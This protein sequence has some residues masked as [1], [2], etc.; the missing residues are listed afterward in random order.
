MTKPVTGVLF[1]VDGTLVDS[2]YL[3]AVA[4]WQAFR[5]Y[6]YD[7]PMA[8]IHRAIG[9][10][11]DKILDALL[12]PDHDSSSDE[13]L[14][15]AHSALYAPHWP[16][17]RP[18]PGARRLLDTCA[19]RG[20]SVVLATSASRPELDALL[21]CLDV[22]SALTAVTSADDASQSKP[23][24][25]ILEVALERSGLSAEEAVFVGDSVWD[26]HAAAQLS[27]PCI[28]LTS[29][30]LCA[31][32]LLDHGAAAI[33]EDPQDLLDHLDEALTS[34]FRKSLAEAG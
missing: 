16:A 9:M 2:V 24:P 27:I 18:L 19:N 1:D 28:G 5:Q 25:D 20:L 12:G 15:A 26:V 30:G 14:L 13:A 22:D 23:A 34:A 8:R 21:R 6:D 11:S 32:E 31:A 3:H 33:Y 17:L 4:W 29:G 10:G 7:V